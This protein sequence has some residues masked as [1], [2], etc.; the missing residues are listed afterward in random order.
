MKTK[1]LIAV[2]AFLFG[3]IVNLHAQVNSESYKYLSTKEKKAN[4]E[5]MAASTYDFFE[6]SDDEVL[7]VRRELRYYGKF[8]GKKAN[9][10]RYTGYALVPVGIAAGIA[11]AAMGSAPVIVAGGV[12][13]VG[14]IVMAVSGEATRELSQSCLDKAN[15]LYVATSSLPLRMDL[16]GGQLALGICTVKNVSDNSILLGPGLN[17]KF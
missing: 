9:T 13:A 5:R 7:A 2:A 17:L 14:G 6:M 16:G 1:I 8:F 3:G 15:S 4:A 11:G 12:A 10:K